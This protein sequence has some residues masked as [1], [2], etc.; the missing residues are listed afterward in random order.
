MAF[1]NSFTM[2]GICSAFPAIEDE[3][4]LQRLLLAGMLSGFV[5]AVFAFS[6]ARVVSEPSIE[7]AISLEEGAAHGHGDSHDE[8]YS[9]DVQRNAGLFTGIVSYSVALGGFLAIGLAYAHGRT[10]V[11]TRATVWLLAGAGY[12]S[13][14]LVPQLIYPASPPGVGSAETI[15]VRT[16]LY[17]LVMLASVA[18]MGASTWVAYRFSLLLPTSVAI[19]AGAAVFAGLSWVCASQF[20]EVSEVPKYFPRG[21]LLEFRINAAM[22]QLLIWGGLAVAYG[23]VAE[24]VLARIQTGVPPRGVPNA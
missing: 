8:T 16:G 2:A 5:V 9:R 19:T 24:F 11:R 12:V 18:G 15:G 17:F 7:R 10:P 4:M 21:L 23:Q 6:F 22:L 13:L 1:T 3:A 14:V 20:P